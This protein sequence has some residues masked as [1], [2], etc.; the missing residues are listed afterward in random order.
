MTSGG[1]LAFEVFEGFDHGGEICGAEGN[2]V[3][4]VVGFFFEPD[5]FFY[6][7]GSHGCGARLGIRVGWTE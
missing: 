2:G 6:D 4:Q 5:V 1:G 3:I 7:G